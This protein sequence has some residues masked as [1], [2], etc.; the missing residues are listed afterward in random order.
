MQV[1]VLAQHSVIHT[2]RESIINGC[3]G[4]GVSP[5]RFPLAGRLDLMDGRNLAAQRHKPKHIIPYLD[6]SSLLPVLD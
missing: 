2:V 4:T 6:V 3:Q 5:F 1:R